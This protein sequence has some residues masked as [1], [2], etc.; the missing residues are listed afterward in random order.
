MRLSVIFDSFKQIVKLLN[1][2]LPQEVMKPSEVFQSALE[3]T[4][5]FQ[6]SLK[7]IVIEFSTHK[8]IK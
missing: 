4:E 8:S 3:T 1:A 5:E 6:W 2:L 7:N